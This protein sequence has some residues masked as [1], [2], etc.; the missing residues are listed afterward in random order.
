MEFIR[1][2]GETAAVTKPAPLKRV[3]G[4]LASVMGSFAGNVQLSRA[5]ASMLGLAGPVALGA[6]A[7]QVKI[8]IVASLGGLALGGEGQGVTFGERF[9]GL[10]Y[11]GA[12][13]TLAVL[14]GTGVSGH[15]AVTNLTMAAIAA[16]AAFFGSLSRPMARAT[17]L[18]ILFAIIAANI[19]GGTSHPLVITFLFFLGA[20][21]T[22]GLSLAL[23]PLFRTMGLGRGALPGSLQ[24][25]PRYAAKQYVRRWWK[26]LAHLSGWQ[27]TVRLTLCL[28]AAS[29]VDW[30]WPHHHGY[31]VL[32]TVVILVRRDIQSS[33]K[34]T[35]QRAIGTVIGVLLTS[36]LLLGTSSIWAAVAMMASMA[37][38]RP[39]LMEIN[40][41]AYAA[42]QTP[43]VLLLLDF[44][45][46][47]WGGVVDRLA[48]T[49]AGC[50]IAMVLG[51]VGWGRV[52][53]SAKSYAAS[54]GTAK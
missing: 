37:A 51:Y 48:A 4:S 13:G 9:R 2:T 40:Y 25:A 33:I 12:A 24:P 3:V 28:L 34:L 53:P 23:R 52:A 27:Y 5:V 6:M 49:L 1:D 22:A 50:A 15:G 31:W 10:L 41:T 45:Q 16:V 20:V 7:G 43:L 14:V 44:G 18:F 26:S 38:V 47:S 21:W 30:L 54:K 8:G 29:G 46:P 17:T 36:L 32:I 19:Q 11:G 35:S 39:I 42:V